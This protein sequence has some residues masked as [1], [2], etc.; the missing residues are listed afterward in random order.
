[1]PEQQHALLRR[2]ERRVAVQW[3]I[4]DTWAWTLDATEV[5]FR[6]CFFVIKPNQLNVDSRLS[7]VPMAD[8]DRDVS[9]PRLLLKAF[10]RL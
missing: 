8:W 4:L 9:V 5:G 1:M 10:W 2:E 7:L 6:F 3:G